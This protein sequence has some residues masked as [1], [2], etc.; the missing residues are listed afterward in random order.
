MSIA[1]RW[2]VL[3]GQDQWEGLLN[4]LDI[5][6]RRYIIH[7]GERTQATYDTFISETNSKYAGA[8]KYAKKNLFARVGLEI[9]NPFKYSV[10][11]Y[12]YAT[13]Q[14][15]VP[16]AFI[17]KSLSRECW[18]KE[19]N[20]IGYVAVATDE[21]K[22][23]LGRRDIMVA[24]R[25]TIRTLEWINNFQFLL[26]PAPIIFGGSGLT[27]PKV[28]EGWYC[29]Y[30]SDDPR[31]PFNTTSA[32]DQVLSEIKRLVDLYKDEEISITVVGHS[33]GGA[34]AT[35]NAV[36]IT[37][38]GYNKPSKAPEKSFPVTAFLYACPR[39]GELNFKRV[40]NG[41]KDLRALRIKN[42]LDI[43]PNYPILPYLDM[44]EEL[45]INT[46]QSPYLR[47]PG[48]ISTWHNLECYLHGVAGT[49]GLDGIFEL[50]VNHDIALTNKSDDS[51][52]DENLV[53]ASWWIEKNKGMV[54]KEDGSWEL[55]D[56]EEDSF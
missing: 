4:P 37:Q 27:D 41:L 40:F 31:S 29:M 12:L 9:G 11:K 42:I 53:P 26:L 38:N 45:E 34:L 3:S 50:V 36:D 23:V 7:Y 2:R 43:V 24:W 51:L 52:K 14:I 30:T 48:T 54:Q 35:L 10:T 19:S 15:P 1:Q 13:S 49:H 32:R 8:S 55:L 21:G 6:L 25:G 17:V 18:S 44:G 39:V 46:Q 33:L 47:S 22:A 20:W 28:H 5:D 56:H 16:D